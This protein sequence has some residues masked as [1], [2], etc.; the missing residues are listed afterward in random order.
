M[1]AARAPGTT[2][3]KAPSPDGETIRPTVESSTKTAGS[4]GKRGESRMIPPLKVDGQTRVHDAPASSVRKA[5]GQAEPLPH[6][7]CTSPT[8][9]AMPSWLKCGEVVKVRGVASS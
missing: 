7:V 5:A 4:A 3:V 1:A 2:A 8:R 9:K 6:P